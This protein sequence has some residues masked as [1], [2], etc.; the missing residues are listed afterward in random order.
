[1]PEERK[2]INVEDLKKLVRTVPDFPKPGILFYDI[3][4]CSKTRPALRS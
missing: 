3:T 1:M 4:T 2:P